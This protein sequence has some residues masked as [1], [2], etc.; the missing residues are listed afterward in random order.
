MTPAAE[1]DVAVVGA[2]VV[3]LA[4]A[5]EL[6]AAGR[7]CAVLEARPRAGGVTSER[8]SGV[9]HAGLHYPATWLRTRLCVEG[10]RLLHAWCEARG[11]AHRRCGKLVIACEAED[12]PELEALLARGRA[13]GVEGLRILSA[14]ETA[15]LEPLAVPRPALLSPASGIVDPA[16]LA[17]SLAAEAAARGAA[18]ICHAEVTGARP[19]ERGWE[20]A[21]ARGTVHAERVVN[22]AGLLA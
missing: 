10:A 11:V 14:E 6:A 12:E 19:L 16:E 13:A 1:V 5:A 21:T 9:V 15:D 2:G 3:G 4:V 18:I 22:A 20:L 17:R 7:S 8:N